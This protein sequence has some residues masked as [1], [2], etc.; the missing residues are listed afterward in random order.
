V[1]ARHGTEP[2]AVALA[3]LMAKPTVTAP[4]ASATTSDQL[5][6]LVAATRLK[7]SA[8]EVTALDQASA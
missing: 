6:T 7:L 5:T 2:A 1:A 3:W 4:I 8:D